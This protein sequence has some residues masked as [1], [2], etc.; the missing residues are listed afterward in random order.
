MNNCADMTF[1]L[2]L[3]P[4]LQKSWDFAES[5]VNTTGDVAFTKAEALPGAAPGTL[6]L[7]LDER[8]RDR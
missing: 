1:V 4:S 3:K 6:H 8:P 5:Q 7:C 2:C